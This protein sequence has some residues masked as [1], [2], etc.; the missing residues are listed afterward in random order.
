MGEILGSCLSVDFLINLL[1]SVLESKLLTH[2]LPT[3]FKD[4]N[5]AHDDALF[6]RLDLIMQNVAQR[7]SDVLASTHQHIGD[8]MCSQRQPRLT[9]CLPK[10]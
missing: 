2:P 6:S 7:C 3:T 8:P 1:R 9:P 5:D 4:H 10:G